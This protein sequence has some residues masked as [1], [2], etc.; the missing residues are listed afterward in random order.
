MPNR[1]Y[2]KRKMASLRAERGNRCENCQRP[3]TFD[4]RG[5]PN[6]QWAHLRPTGLSGKGRG[7]NHRVL[8]I[9][10]NPD[11]YALLCRDCHISFDL[12]A[13]PEPAPMLMEYL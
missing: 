1:G 4:E 5:H 2:C 8:D 6:L 3:L 13:A 7:Y 10:R 12:A 9:R 11:H